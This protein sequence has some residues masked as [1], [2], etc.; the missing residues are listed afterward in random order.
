[1]FDMDD[2]VTW[3]QTTHKGSAIDIAPCLHPSLTQGTAPPQAKDLHIGVETGRRIRQMPTA[4]KDAMLEPEPSKEVRVLLRSVRFTDTLL[5]QL[6][7]PHILTTHNRDLFTLGQPSN[8]SRYETP[9]LPTK[10]LKWLYVQI[11]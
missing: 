3:L 4:I 2:I 8:D 9:Q 10:E 6:L 5:N 1:M 7:D 11:G